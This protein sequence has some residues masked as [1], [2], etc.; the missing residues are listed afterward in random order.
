MPIYRACFTIISAC[1]EAV[2]LPIS[3]VNSK[4]MVLR[5]IGKSN[6][7]PILPVTEP[8][9]QMLRD[10]WKIHRSPRRLFPSR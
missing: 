8:T 9:L 6:K 2:T 1:G 10:V 4:Q 3:A 5:V 7:E